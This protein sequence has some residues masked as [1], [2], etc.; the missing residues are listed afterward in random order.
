MKAKAAIVQGALALAGL[1]AAYATWQ[2]PPAAGPGDVSV[3]SLSRHDLKEVR[4]QSPD[5]TVMLSRGTLHGDEV[6][7]VD[8]D[9]HPV[10]KPALAGKPPPAPETWHR[11]L[12]GNDLAGKLLEQLASL[13]A[14]RAL[15]KLDAAKLKELGLESPKQHLEVK[16]EGETFAFALSTEAA[17]VEQPYLRRERDGEVFLLGGMLVADLNGAMRLVDRKL[18]AFPPDA[19]DTVTL[20][21]DGKTR[22]YSA[23]VVGGAFLPE[24][25]AGGE[26]KPDPRAKSWHDQ[27]WRS[28]SEVLLGE[29]EV[30]AEGAP[31]PVFRVDYARRGRPVGWVELAK[32]GKAYFARSE[33][34]AGWARLGGPVEDLVRQADQLMEK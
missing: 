11:R 22:T 21:A 25:S 18:H 15:G 14:T 31:S 26:A 3:I 8:E 9:E 27:L 17:G 5:R 32:S 16:A 6:V 30:P 23:K 2:R 34:T 7:W 20:K 4:F 29:G 12:V 19:F 33:H 28:R 10:A 13:K 24:L 1:G